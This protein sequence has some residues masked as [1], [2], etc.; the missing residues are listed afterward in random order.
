[1][2]QSSEPIGQK[3]IDLEARIRG[4]PPPNIMKSLQNLAPNVTINSYT[5]LEAV[6]CNKD[7]DSNSE[8]LK[9]DFFHRRESME[10]LEAACAQNNNNNNNINNHLGLP[11]IKEEINENN[12]NSLN[13]TTSERLEDSNSEKRDSV[14][15]NLSAKRSVKRRLDEVPRAPENKQNSEKPRKLK[16]IVRKGGETHGSSDLSD[17]SPEITTSNSLNNTAKDKKITDFFD[18]NSKKNVRKVELRT[19]ENYRSSAPFTSSHTYLNNNMHNNFSSVDANTK[20]N[21]KENSSSMQPEGEDFKN[22]LILEKENKRLKSE[23]ANLSSILSEKD[24]I[25]NKKDRL[26]NQLKEEN[27]K[28]NEKLVIAMNEQSV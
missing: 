17:G 14:V 12:Q 11:T 27:Q 26:A 20:L 16:T 25:F 13:L 9:T 28:L 24:E 1:M 10:P 21:G 23:L 6:E 19:S 22:H 7:E 4:Q 15:N 5:P 18:A 2:L 8:E 3:I